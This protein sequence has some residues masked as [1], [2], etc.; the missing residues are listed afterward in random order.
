MTDIVNIY[1]RCAQ[2]FQ[3]FPEGIFYEV[4]NYVLLAGCDIGAK[5]SVP[6]SVND[7]FI[8]VYFP[9]AVIVVIAK[10]CIVIILICTLTYILLSSDFDTGQV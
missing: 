6:L 3:P 2:C 4:C 10:P 8:K 5:I 1:F 7:I 9:V